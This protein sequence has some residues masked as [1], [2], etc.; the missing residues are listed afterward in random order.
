MLRLFNQCPS[1]W[2]AGYESPESESKNFGSLLDTR[3][4]VPEQFAK[5]FSVRPKTYKNEDGEEKPFNLNAKVCRK[6]VDEQAGRKIVTADD[7]A[8]VDIARERMLADETIAELLAASDR[9]VWITADWKDKATGFTIPIQALI[10]F[11]PRPDTPFQK[12]IGDLKTVRSAAQTPFQR[13]IY[14]LGWH[15]QASLYQDIY[16]ASTGED[17]PDFLFIIQENYAPYQVGRRLLSQDFIE[18]GRQTYQAGLARYAKCLKSGT[19]PGYDPAEEF[20]L[21]SP[22]PFMEFQALSEKLEADAAEALQ[23]NDEVIP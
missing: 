12:G 17:R 18:I 6:W 15:L 10:D 20:S 3:V 5:R 11:V 14:Q 13:Q 23:E 22:E 21:V 2:R 4:L 7:M 8:E 19:W 9:Q 1:R 16:I